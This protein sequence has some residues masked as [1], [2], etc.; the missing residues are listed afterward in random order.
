MG[1]HL[2]FLPPTVFQDRNSHDL[3]AD[4]ADEVQL[5]TDAG[6]LVQFLRSW[7]PGNTT[8]PTIA[9]ELAAEMAARKFWGSQDVELVEAW[10]TVRSILCL[11]SS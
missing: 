11:V 2:T 7:T 9:T 1:G 10:V 6:R 3:I 5:Y 8:L 4:L